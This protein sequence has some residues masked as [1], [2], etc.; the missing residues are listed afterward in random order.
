[1]RSAFDCQMKFLYETVMNAIVHRS[2]SKHSIIPSEHIIW[3]IGNC[4]E[5]K[6]VHSCSYFTGLDC[7]KEGNIV[8]SLYYL[9]LPFTCG[10]V[11]YQFF[12]GIAQFK[13]GNKLIE[14][15]SERQL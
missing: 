3:G 7:T 9:H 15:F 5:I 13:K 6:P 8:T 12:T 10:L 2:F 14:A 1:M 11:L 4:G